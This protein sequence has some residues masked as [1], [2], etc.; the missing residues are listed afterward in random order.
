MKKING[1]SP[2]ETVSISLQSSLLNRLDRYSYKKQLNR[3]QVIQFAIQRY[4]A[5]EM[6]TDPDFW[7]AVYDKY[8]ED[9]KL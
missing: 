5:A 2:S 1:Q 9:G 3:S 8:E 4:L 7:D 6:V